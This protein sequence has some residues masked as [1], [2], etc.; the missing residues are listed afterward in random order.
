MFDTTYKRIG[1]ALG[2]TLTTYFVILNLGKA[3]SLVFPLMLALFISYRMQ[4][5]IQRMEDLLKW[6]RSVI[7]IFSVLIA[8][9]VV[10][11]FGFLLSQL[12]IALA[13]Q[14]AIIFPQAIEEFTT[15]YH[16]VL[17][18]YHTYFSLVPTHWQS[19]V[20]NSINSLTKE[21]GSLAAVLATSIVNRL[22]F[23]PNI[24]FAFFFTLMTT[25]FV[26]RDF[27][28]VDSCKNTV[29]GFL[30]SKPLYHEIK[31]NVFVVFVGY[32]KAQL[33]LMTITF[34]I[35]LV[36]L[37]ILKV[38]YAPLIALFIALV[39]AL[40]MLGPAAIYIPWLIGR[41]LVGNIS[42]AIW[43]GILYL[44]ATLTRQTLEPKIVSTQI[45][46]HPIIT[47][48]AMYAGIKLFGIFGLILGPLSAIVILK[49]YKTLTFPQ[50]HEH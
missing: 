34:A 29:L 9:G 7:A 5:F 46:V 3:I 20:E 37:S 8:I 49:S 40:P 28:R 13:T 41:V 50:K 23:L 14:L 19:I 38:N 44:S 24:L 31:K 6:P 39:D 10:V 27:E 16:T 45:G 17:T 21:L 42:G 33:I 12:M 4:P 1:L 2:L 22:T 36:G 30:N 43:L 18:A 25:Y 15:F 35:S 26:T 32:I 11:L 47:L 48:S